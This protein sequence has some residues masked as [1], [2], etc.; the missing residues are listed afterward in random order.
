MNRCAFR[1]M[2]LASAS[3]L[4]VAA[5]PAAGGVTDYP[6]ASD[7][8]GTIV[9]I[10][11]TAQLQV[12]TGSATQSGPISESGGSFGVEKIGGGI[13][14]L[15]G[16]N[17]YTG[18]TL[19]STGTLVLDSAAATSGSSDYT[20]ASGATLT[21][22]SNDYYVINSLSGAGTVQFNHFATLSVGNIG[23]TGSTTFSG[24]LTG[25]GE[26]ELYGDGSLTLDGNVTH[27]LTNVTLC[28]CVTGG[29][30]L[31]NGIFN[32]ASTT[33]IEAGTLTVDR[34]AQWNTGDLYVVGAMVV[35]N[36]QV[37]VSDFIGVGDPFV[38]PSSLIIRNGATVESRNGVG[39][40]GDIFGTLATITI[41]GTGSQLR[42]S[43]DVLEIGGFSSGTVTVA[44]G[45]ALTA[46]NGLYIG[47]QSR[48]NIGTGALAGSVSAPGGFTNDGQIVADFTDTLTLGDAIDGSGSLTKNGSGTLTL[49]G[50]N[51]YTGGTVISGGTVI[52]GGGA[53]FGIGTV[54]MASGTM[55]SFSSLSTIANNFALR[56]NGI[57]FVDIG[58]DTEL[59]GIISDANPGTPG[60]LVKSG[61]GVLM[62]TGDNT[63]TGGTV[64]SGGQIM[65]GGT[66]LGPSTTGS[67][68]SGSIVNNGILR[69]M[70]LAATTVTGDISGTGTVYVGGG[71]LTPSGALLTLSGN[72]TY[73]G[74]TNIGNNSLLV[75]GSVTGF[76][77]N[78]A[79]TI[80][81]LTGSGIS[82]NGFN[83]TIGSLASISTSSSVYT[84]T[85]ATLTT[86][87]DNTST[88]FYGRLLDGTSGSLS[89]TK[90]GS[91]TFT[92]GA[93][94]SIFIGSPTISNTYTGATAINGGTLALIGVATIADSSEIAD[95]ANFDISA[96][97]PISTTV[98][99][100]TGSGIVTLGEKKL[101]IS[102][103]LGSFGGSFTGTGSVE[104]SGGT[105][106]L[107]GASTV[108]FAVDAGA[109]LQIGDGG[110]AGAVN[111]SITDNAG[112]IFNRRD[113]VTFA[114]VI[115]GSGSLTQAGIGIMTLTGANT[116]TGATTVAAGALVV[117]GSIAS[118]SGVTVQNG[119]TLAGTGTV[120]AT[121]VQSGG[122]LS[123]GASPGD[124]ATLTIGGNLTLAV[125]SATALEFSPA[126]ADKLAVTGA[127]AID[128]TLFVNFAGVGGYGAGQYALITSTGLLSGTFANFNTLGSPSGFLTSLSYDSHDV[129]LN[130]T[131]RTFVWS[132]A[133]GSS[134]WNTATNWQLGT[135]P[136]VTDAA[137]FDVTANAAV[138][139]S[140]AISVKSLQFNSGA[141]AY[142][143][144]ILG[145]ASGAASLTLAAGGIVDNSGKPPVI[146]V[147]GISG[148]AGTL[149]FF[150]SGN[151]AGASL[152][153]GAFGTVS[154]N[155]LTDAGAGAQLTAQSGGV[156]DFSATA[157][158][159]GDNKV[160]AGSIA[161]AGS[162]V[163][164]ANTLTVGALGTSTEV[165]GAISGSGGLVKTGGGTLLLSG[166]STYTGTTTVDAGILDVNGVI[167][168]NV[169]LAAGTLKGHGTVGGII[170]TS[171]AT[172]APG[173]S[174]G[175]LNTGTI[176][177][178]AGSAY[179]VEVNAAGQSDLINASGAATL[180]GV[181]QTVAAAGD[182]AP[183]T[184]YRILN[185][186]GGISG[187]FASV[188]S[189]AA[190]L[191]PSLIYGPTSVDLRL[192]RN[193]VAF[194]TSYG[195]SSNQVGVGGAVSAAGIG[196]GLYDSLA[197]LAGNAPA[198]PAALDSLSGEIHA[199][200]RSAAAE[201]GR[202]VRQAVLATLASAHDGTINVWGDLFAV[203]GH[204][205]GDSNAATANRS[206]GG[207]IAGADI[208]LGDGW[209]AGLAG[210]YT[211]HALSLRD[212]ASHASGDSGHL[213]GYVGWEGQGWHIKAGADFGWGGDDIRR[214]VAFLSE[215]QASHQ[216]LGTTQL[217]ADAGYAFDTSLGTLEPYAQLVWLDVRSG[218]FAE[219]GGT[220]SALAGTA[221]SDS[222]TYGNFGLRAHLSSFDL[223]GV[224]LTPRLD[225]GLQH[226]FQAFAPR[227]TV[228][229]GA[230]GFT[231]S[232]SPLARD[233]FVAGAGF[234][235]ALSPT[236]HLSLGYDGTM[237]SRGASHAVH[238]ALRLGL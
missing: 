96:I 231:A 147:S 167:A 221:A 65:V 102:A 17:T 169:I 192:M 63:Y 121:T 18:A 161:G 199:T 132:A 76:S 55:L 160:S 68:G 39:V 11:N 187:S 50:A 226:G 27:S 47:P 8:G 92:L 155:G 70:R 95:N 203:S 225:L 172:V 142:S 7:N 75:A 216:S 60:S 224:I 198:V 170:A 180:D 101:I 153:A 149:N 12:L 179:Q 54:T 31:H 72:N 93:V 208:G 67:L 91:G 84:T 45:A 237:A 58:Q 229:L 13:L 174:I 51:S 30:T 171:G 151:A 137:I 59:S 128:G 71:S 148:S 238:A 136:T 154:F 159:N 74:T 62:L 178:A 28:G 14:T 115:S 227:Q 210:A 141:P 73:S 222:I 194:G 97:T 99:A 114:A 81:T 82:L 135:A 214:E 25:D 106:I 86:G 124:T 98:K 40:D 57:V 152:T 223:G 23:A 66:P 143:I 36:A 129:F 104:L 215:R 156:V 184:T 61:S 130:L 204:I 35:D 134:D 26:L 94:P 41:T 189:S 1:A 166:T 234:D 33:D 207:G 125:G 164:G 206:M 85:A 20:V 138:T 120:S 3:L 185:A 218:G 200:I 107:T 139:V 173:N 77:P 232:G 53:A 195:V 217:F 49:S 230:A 127:A 176:S 158:A 122:T 236:A 10:D 146:A 37:T 21:L 9:L 109:S 88:V 56:G 133:P 24:T 163:L 100:L 131:P 15:S 123:P 78:S 150:G 19:V 103:G 157:G 182:Y 202:A 108:A 196:S 32:V 181:V 119:G 52:A 165:S 183:V 211:G 83:S 235:L 144:N 29:L 191:V 219:T 5:W 201:D 112:I 105:M 6:D 69:F 177:F 145:G 212:R 80:N 188:A 90:T 190:N 116:Y 197:M 228:M 113:S 126:A 38:S 79:F 118:S 140:Q 43:G 175:T 48:L 46:S 213:I 205:D 186:A 89:L 2:L 233:A 87:G 162:F 4:S 64:I 34:G 16:T 117:T 220:L 193:D 22:D 168:S 110:T 42:V 209:R 111:N 44:D